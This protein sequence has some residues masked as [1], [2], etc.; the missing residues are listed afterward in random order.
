MQLNNA[1]FKSVFASRPNIKVVTLTE[2]HECISTTQNMRPIDRQGYFM[3]VGIDHDNVVKY[4]DTVERLNKLVEP[5][6]TSFPLQHHLERFNIM[7][8]FCISAIFDPDI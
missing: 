8:M 6:T 1:H 5:P 4:V 7:L 3:S 2:V